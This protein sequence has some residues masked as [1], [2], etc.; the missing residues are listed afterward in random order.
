[1]VRLNADDDWASSVTVT[2]VAFAA[3]SVSNPIQTG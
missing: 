2:M 3:T 1:M